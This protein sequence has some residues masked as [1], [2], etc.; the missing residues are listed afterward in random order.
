MISFRIIIFSVILISSFLLFSKNIRKIINLIKLGKSDNRL[1]NK[2]KRLK[3]VISIAFLQS[4]I[5]NDKKAGL[6]HIII[7]WGFL[8]LLFTVI[9]SIIQ[10]FSPTFSFNFLGYFFSV[11][12]FLTD[13]FCISIIIACL[14]ALSRRFIFKIPR[15]QG[16]YSEQ[17]DAIIVIS[18][19]LII[20]ISL[21]INISYSEILFPKNYSKHFIDNLI[22]INNIKN[23][24]LIYSVSWWIHIVSILI[25]LN[26]LPFSKHLHILFAIPNVFFSNQSHKSLNNIDFDDENIT[27][28]GANHI[29]DLSWK[30]ILD[31]YSCTHCGRCTNECPAFKSG[32]KL[33]PRELM[34]KIR[35]NSNENSKSLTGEDLKQQ[36]PFLETYDNNKLWECTTCGACMEVCPVNIEH[37]PSIIDFRRNQIMM[38]SDFPAELQSVFENLENNS[39]PW[40]FSMDSKLD[41]A[42]DIKVNLCKDIENFDVLF[43]V[44]CAGA[45]DEKA[46]NTSKAMIKILE[47]ANINY[48]ILGTEEKCNGD[49][50]RRCGNEYLADSMIKD[51]I[52]TLNK[53]Q[54]NS[55]VTTCPHCYNTFKNE[56]PNFGYS[57]NIVHHTEFINDLLITKKLIPTQ[58]INFNITYHDSCY[59]SRYNDITKPPREILKFIN[60]GDFVETNQYSKNNLCCGA[61]GGNIFLEHKNHEKINN[62]RTKELV[63]TN[64]DTI[65]LNCPFCNIMLNDSI[66][67]LNITSINTSDIAELVAKAL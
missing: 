53:Y 61:G 7:F 42:K 1:N 22:K 6:I 11:I 31:A 36:L 65:A 52:E 5:L 21:I 20:V 47:K 62:I 14:I 30:N 3:N 38:E 35:E 41:W 63:A 16:D 57:K 23:A 43:W 45:F 12:T 17:K 26:Y 32:M 59:L 49:I 34:V 64:C 25:F 33:D 51:N 54:F 44:G 29:T 46:K 24:S 48:A 28:Y 10:G 37:I 40:A 19:I 4:K 56:Y 60:N 18:L 66:K 9:E 15:L 8:T 55:I 50:A 2:N 27:N 13:L 67:E 39:N 58:K